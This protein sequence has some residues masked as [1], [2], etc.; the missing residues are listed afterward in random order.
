MLV[1]KNYKEEGERI[2]QIEIETE[3]TQKEMLEMKKM[4]E[5]VCEKIS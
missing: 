3:Q 1:N 5:N 4:D 2:R